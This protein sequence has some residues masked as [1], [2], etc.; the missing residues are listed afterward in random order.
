MPRVCTWS[1]TRPARRGYRASGTPCAGGPGPVGPGASGAC[2]GRWRGGA[3][4]TVP[5]VAE[6][7]FM[8]VARLQWHGAELWVSRSGYTG[9]DGFEISLPGRRSRPSR[10][11]CLDNRCRRAHRPGRARYAAAGG[12]VAALRTGPRA[13]HHAGRG[14]PDLGHPEGPPPRRGAGR[15]LSGRRHHRGTDGRRRAAQARAGLLPQ[16]RAPMRAGTEVF[17][18][19]KA[20]ASRSASSP[21]AVSRPASVRPSRWR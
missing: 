6:M 12:R 4:R 7:R 8:D 9:E 3:G 1:S 19:E 16:G 2:R 15:R 10:G 13:R 5:G 18:T 20:A 21:R 17:A 11:R 14:G